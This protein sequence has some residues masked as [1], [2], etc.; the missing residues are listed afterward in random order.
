[1]LMFHHF[2]SSAGSN[3]MCLLVCCVSWSDDKGVGSKSTELVRLISKSSESCRSPIESGLEFWQPMPKSAFLYPHSAADWMNWCYQAS[4][5]SCLWA[6]PEACQPQQNWAAQRQ[7]CPPAAEAALPDCICKKAVVGYC[8]CL[9][10]SRDAAAAPVLLTPLP[11][12]RMLSCTQP[13]PLIFQLT[14]WKKLSH[15]LGHVWASRVVYNCFAVGAIPIRRVG[16][17]NQESVK[18]RE[19]GMCVKGGRAGFH[20]F[21]QKSSLWLMPTVHERYKQT[22]VWQLLPKGSGEVCVSQWHCVQEMYRKNGI[23]NPCPSVM[24]QKDISRSTENLT[25]NSLLGKLYPCGEGCFMCFR[26]VFHSGGQCAVSQ[27]FR[28]HGPNPWA[29]NTLYL[30]KMV[31]V[32]LSLHSSWEGLT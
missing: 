15:S 12:V 29:Q 6:C 17:I 23:C 5:S 9:K 14:D 10:Y 26:A 18:C 7:V 16:G 31:M 3:T 4:W 19:H 28:S 11:R 8:L 30:T 2:R 25:S 21:C 13:G 20:C 22:L 27:G 24:L 1:M 32:I